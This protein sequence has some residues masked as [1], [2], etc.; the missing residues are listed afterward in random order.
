MYYWNNNGWYPTTTGYAN[1]GM[2]NQAWA[3]LSLERPSWQGNAA[4][5]SIRHKSGGDQTHTAITVTDY[6]LTSYFNVAHNGN[7]TSSGILALTSTTAASNKIQWKDDGAGDWII[8]S[9]GVAQ[10]DGFRITKVGTADIIAFRPSIIQAYANIA[11]TGTI[12]ATGHVTSAFQTL[13]ADPTTTD[14]S[15][16]NQRMVKNSTSGTLKLWAN[17]AGTMK[18]VALT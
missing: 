2:L 9:G 10:T 8:A 6:G 4:L 13:S 14:I 11:T 18:S 5:L 1:L 12:T 7:I 17:D 3:A 16:G 15:A